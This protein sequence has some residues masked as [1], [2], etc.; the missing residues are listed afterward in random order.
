MTTDLCKKYTKSYYDYTFILYLQ[1]DIITFTIITPKQI[2]TTC[3][4][5][6]S[7][8]KKYNIK[9][10]T[11]DLFDIIKNKIN[12]YKYE[13]YYDYNQIIFEFDYNSSYKK[14]EL[15]LI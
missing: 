12:N 10:N 2:N 9:C 4:I 14:V 11:T 13:L 15:E 8:C 6:D 1:E 5:S 3:N 7:F